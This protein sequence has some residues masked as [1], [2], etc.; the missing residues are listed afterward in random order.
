MEKIGVANMTLIPNNVSS[1]DFS[2]A[3]FFETSNG[4]TN[5]VNRDSETGAR[6]IRGYTGYRHIFT[7]K[8]Y[9]LQKK[10]IC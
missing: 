10:N 2:R 5:C 3:T 4:S 8:R 1:Y 9:I 7:N 6:C